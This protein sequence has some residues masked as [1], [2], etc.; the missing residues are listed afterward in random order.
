MKA[1]IAIAVLALAGCADM[2]GPSYELGNGDA[3]YD[4]L[5]AAT[6]ACEA[7]GGQ[8]KLRSGYD[9]RLLSNYLCIGGKAK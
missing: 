1:L 7:E 2:S 6:K 4:A 3:N 5:T 9:S 8:V